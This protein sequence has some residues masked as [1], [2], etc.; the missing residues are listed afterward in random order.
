MKK[1][2]WTNIK[3]LWAVVLGVVIGVFGFAVLPVTAQQE[4]F[5]IVSVDTD[6]DAWVVTATPYGAG[7]DSMIAFTKHNAKTGIT[8][9]AWC[10]GMCLD[11]PKYGEG[12]W[13]ELPVK[14]Q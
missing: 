4:G 14:R 10:A 11:Q 7:N 2:V 6:P 13:H 5:S 12:E 1:S 3:L 9:I 8:L